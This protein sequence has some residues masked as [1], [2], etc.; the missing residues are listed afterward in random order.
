MRDFPGPECGVLCILIVDI[1]SK[2][3]LALFNL[4]CERNYHCNKGPV[5]VDNITIFILYDLYTVN[6]ARVSDKDCFFNIYVI[7]LKNGHNVPLYIE[8]K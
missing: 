1:M 3:A 6:T 7:F 2:S 8:I 5:I 4:L